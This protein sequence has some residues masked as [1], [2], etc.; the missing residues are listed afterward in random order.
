[1]INK[2]S[3]FNLFFGKIQ[4]LSQRFYPRSFAPGIK[5][6]NIMLK[7]R[8]VPTRRDCTRILFFDMKLVIATT[9]KNKLV[10]IR[11]KFSD[12]RGLDLVS[13][14]DYKNPP[15]V[16][17]DGATFHENAHKKASAIASFAGLAAMADDSGLEIDALGGR[18]GV[19]SARF[20]GEGASD[21]DRNRLILQ[22]MEGIPEGSRGARFVCVIAIALPGGK[23]YFAVGRCEGV[24]AATMSG[25]HGFGYDPIFYLPEIGQTMAELPLEEKNK[26]SHRARALDRA[27][28]ILLSLGSG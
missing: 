27:R 9:N 16:I 26:I 3:Y 22:E 25:T 14:E 23:S 18:P 1:M 19:Y 2:H 10:E 21:L 13:L 8:P 4:I 24:I 15:A 12:I 17:E 7:K 5:A 11:H 28:E 6:Q 20:G